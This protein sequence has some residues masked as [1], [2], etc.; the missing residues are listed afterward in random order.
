MRDVWVGSANAAILRYPQKTWTEPVVKITAQTS[1][2]DMESVC[3]AHVCARRRKTQRR[4]TVASSVSVTTSTV[5]APQTS[6]VE[7]SV[8]PL[9]RRSNYCV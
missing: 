1:A 8:T 5:T 3:V 7:V 6:C 9:F 2:A 4:G